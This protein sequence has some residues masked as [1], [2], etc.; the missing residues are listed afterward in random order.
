VSKSKPLQHTLWELQRRFGPQVVGLASAKRSTE[1]IPTGF[2]ALD[3][4]LS[5][6]GIARKHTTAFTGF[7]TSGMTTLAL[8]VMAN[9]QKHG[10]AVVYIDRDETFDGD[11]AAR[12]GVDLSHLLLITPKKNALA[13]Q[14]TADIV[15]AQLAA[16]L[17]LDLI[18]HHRPGNG[19]R[20]EL[21][22]MLHRTAPTLFKTHCALL[23][24]LPPTA[25]ERLTARLHTQLLIERTAWL[26]HHH[27]VCGY[28]TQITILKDRGGAVPRQIEL[29]IAFASVVEG[30][31]T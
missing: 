1:S 25:D 2:G 10:E 28:R 6:C 29:D 20:S 16:V 22:A 7:P 12:C 8:H 3:E 5:E 17:V 24:L 31:G 30:G 19:Q 21:A 23:L 15:A 4:A 26:R 13:L 18:S 27:D 11:Y 14:M 9:A